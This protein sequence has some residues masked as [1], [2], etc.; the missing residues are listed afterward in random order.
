MITVECICC[1]RS[2]SQGP[3]MLFTGATPPFARY[4]A[5]EVLA[6]AWPVTSLSYT[7]VLLEVEAQ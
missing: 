3:A 1:A 5:A 4:E 6:L 2:R 7:V